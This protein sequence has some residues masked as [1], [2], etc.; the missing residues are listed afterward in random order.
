MGTGSL[1]VAGA[2][3]DHPPPSSA[4]VKKRVELHFYPPI[5]AFMACSR[6]NFTSTERYF[7]EQK[8]FLKMS[9]EKA[10]FVSHRTTACNLTEILVALRSNPAESNPER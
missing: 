7:R 9:F 10:E 6:V 4:E 1:F 8:S 5:C 3:V 2:S